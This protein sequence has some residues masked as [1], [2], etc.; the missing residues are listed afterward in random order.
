MPSSVRAAGPR[1]ASGSAPP[2]SAEV[3]HLDAV[4]PCELGQRAAVPARP[5][6]SKQ[7][8]QV[9]L[10][11]LRRQVQP[12]AD[13][14]V[15][16]ARDHQLEHVH[17]P[18][19]HAERAQRRRHLRVAPAPARHRRPRLAEHRPAAPGQRG[20][21]RRAAKN[22]SASRSQRTGSPQP[23]RIAARATSS[24]WTCM[25]PYAPSGWR[26]RRGRR[27]DQRGRL[28]ARRPCRPRTTASIAS[29]AS[30]NM[31]MPI[32][33]G[34]RGVLGPR[35]A[36]RSSSSMVCR[37]GPEHAGRGRPTWSE[38]PG[39]TWTIIVSR[40]AGQRVE[41]VRARTTGSA[42]TRPYRSPRIR[43]SSGSRASAWSMAACMACV[44][45]ARARAPRR[46]TGGR[47]ARWRGRS[48]GWPRRRPGPRPG[49]RPGRSRTARCRRG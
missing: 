6:R 7:A 22:A 18:A 12:L 48:G 36:P 15:R 11:G 39:A 47:P 37:S 8:G 29:P 28:A 3:T 44:V 27:L 17:L 9:P 10:D 16:Q 40:C 25:T 46:A 24:C 32:A 49:T 23:S 38:G 35:G 26:R 13:L 2:V 4:R 41:V 31:A 21:S 20:R 19:R 43:G 1:R 30:A 33:L 34:G 5:V 14:P 45:A 42:S